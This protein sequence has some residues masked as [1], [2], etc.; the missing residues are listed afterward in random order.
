MFAAAEKVVYVLSPTAVSQV[1][2]YEQRIFQSCWVA[3]NF[4]WRKKSS[5]TP[6]KSWAWWNDLMAHIF[7]LCFTK[8]K[9]TEFSF[10]FPCPSVPAEEPSMIILKLC[11]VCNLVQ[12][13]LTTPRQLACFAPTQPTKM[14]MCL[15]LNLGHLCDTD[16]YLAAKGKPTV[17]WQQSSPMSITRFPL[18]FPVSRGSSFF[19]RANVF[20]QKVIVKSNFDPRSWGRT[21]VDV[22]WAYFQIPFGYFMIPFH[23]SRTWVVGHFQAAHIFEAASTVMNPLQLLPL[24][25]TWKRPPL[26]GNGDCG[27]R[28]QMISS[29][30]RAHQ[31][32]KWTHKSKLTLHAVDELLYGSLKRKS[33]PM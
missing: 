16:Y 31:G 4:P 2:K 1:M 9:A 14:S 3:R 17:I 23:C 12:F 29:A 6:R 25:T 32:T 28:R 33:N 19:V 21:V 27:P 10:I 11:M 22:S 13:S 30:I 5:P 24:L 26:N 15:C 18:Y 20:S 8:F 7:L